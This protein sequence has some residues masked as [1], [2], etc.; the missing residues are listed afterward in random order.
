LHPTQILSH[1]FTVQIALLRLTEWS[2]VMGRDRRKNFRV[3]WHSPATIYVGALARRC[4]LWN[5]SNGGAKI[6]G[7]RAATIPDEFGLRIAPGQRV[8]ACRVA[9]RT[10]DSVGV[11]FTDQPASPAPRRA[12]R[13]EREAVD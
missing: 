11:R 12:V 10:A 7:V 5:F 13:R 4:T 8:L 3:E 1:P 6:T 9:W 2:H